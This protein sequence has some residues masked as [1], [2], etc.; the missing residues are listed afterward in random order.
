MWQK[1]SRPNALGPESPYRRPSSSTNTTPTRPTHRRAHSAMPAPPPPPNFVLSA[2]RPRLSVATTNVPSPMGRLQEFSRNP[3]ASA[4]AVSLPTLA[5]LDLQGDTPVSPLI[6]PVRPMSRASIISPVDRE[7]LSPLSIS[8]SLPPEDDLTEEDEVVRTSFVPPPQPASRPWSPRSQS[9]NDVR[10]FGAR[11]G[12]NSSASGRPLSRSGT[13][14]ARHPSLS[15]FRRPSLQTDLPQSISSTSVSDV[16]V[17]ATWSLS[18][19]P[20]A[21]AAPEV[22][23]AGRLNRFSLGRAQ[24]LKSSASYTSKRLQGIASLSNSPSM[25]AMGPPLSIPV[26]AALPPKAAT[27]PPSS[28]LHGRSAHLVN[29]R[30]TH[31]SPNLAIPLEHSLGAMLPPP[32]PAPMI[33]DC[34]RRPNT[35]SAPQE[36]GSVANLMA[37]SMTGRYA[38]GPPLAAGAG[39]CLSSSPGSLSL[40]QSTNS[41]SSSILLPSPTNSVMSLPLM[42]HGARGADSK[43]QFGVMSSDAQDFETKDRGRWWKRPLSAWG[44]GAAIH[45]LRAESMM[46]NRGTRLTGTLMS[47]RREFAGGMDDDE[48]EFGRVTDGDGSRDEEDFLTMDDI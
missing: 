28:L 38:A 37:A 22:D 43:A 13:A 33:A 39:V 31:S 35:L 4:S 19:P 1:V 3:V 45:A 11:R 8:S 2:A 17:M 47:E 9:A 46:G 15:S 26:R 5:E 6:R 12:S 41:D 29:H 21:Q 40:S 25:G 18:D 36:Q 23:T 44:D 20:A 30:H 16:A 14:L 7:P 42:P 27:Q 32:R 10:P 24:S 48:E 34:S